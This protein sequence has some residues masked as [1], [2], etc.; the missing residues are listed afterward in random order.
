MSSPSLLNP[1][2]SPYDA[3]GLRPVINAAGLR[4]AHGG[5]LMAP[6]VRDAMRR[7]GEAFV[8]LDELVAVASQLLTRWTGAPA[9]LVTPGAAAGL[10]L[11]TAA[12]IAGGDPLRMLALPDTGGMERRVLLPPGHRSSYDASFRAAGAQRVEVADEAELAD[13]LRRGAALVG[14]FAGAE[15]SSSMRFERIVELARAHRVPVLV[16]AA[17]GEPAGPD[18]WLERGADLVIYSGG[19][20]LRGPQECGLLLGRQHLVR[21]ATLLAS[22]GQ[23][24]GRGYKVS[25]E[26]L[27]GMLAALELWFEH[28]DAAAERAR[29][30]DDLAALAACLDLPEVHTEVLRGTPGRVQP[31]LRVSW[32]GQRYRISGEGLWRSL[33][34]GT[35]SVVTRELSAGDAQIEF[36]PINLQPGEAQQV[37]HAVSTLLQLPRPAPVPAP[38]VWLFLKGTW[39][40][41]LLLGNATRSFVVDLD[42]QG[43]TLHGKCVGDGLIGKA[44]G[45]L[46]A[47]DGGIRLQLDLRFPFQG[48][49]VQYRLQARWPSTI[50]PDAVVERVLGEAVLGLTDGARLWPDGP[51]IG[52]WQFGRCSFSAERLPH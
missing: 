42:Q 4:T 47:D 10:T 7:A 3:L 39:R 17:S 46:T 19:K 20:R 52:S 40:V 21:A 34:A 31:L 13:A 48:Q 45:R 18:P 50:D 41:S 5:T 28:R 15:R 51:E 29:W 38:A 26:S 35:P 36:D 37:G 1:Q 8:Q 14:T 43:S 27:V 25:K 22:P 16:D 11:A 49:C 32:N 23:T 6:E 30:H 12:C 24:F 2:T 33:L 9:G 44:A